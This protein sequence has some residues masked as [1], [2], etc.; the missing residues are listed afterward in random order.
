MYY[1]SYHAKALKV[2][3]HFA[4]KN[5]KSCKHFKKKVIQFATRYYF[6]V[7]WKIILITPE[8]IYLWKSKRPNNWFNFQLILLREYS[9]IIRWKFPHFSS[10]E[11]SIILY[12]GFHIFIIL[13]LFNE[14]SLDYFFKFC[15][16]QYKV[17]L[18]TSNRYCMPH[19]LSRWIRTLRVIYSHVFSHIHVIFFGND[20]Q[21]KTT[22]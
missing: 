11:M 6:H 17:N 5:I 4:G 15:Q 14:C 20:D 18:L 13:T 8:W 2:A 7:H 16:N 3:G 1:K 9:I 12:N 19:H 22:K 10:H 21:W